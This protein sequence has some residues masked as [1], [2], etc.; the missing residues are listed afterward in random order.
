MDDLNK[1]TRQ[2]HA[3]L[4]WKLAP[5]LDVGAEYVWSER[6][7]ESG[8]QGTSSRVQGAVKYAF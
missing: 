4:I 2:V 1:S 5:Q 6:K 8:A 7:V 3:N